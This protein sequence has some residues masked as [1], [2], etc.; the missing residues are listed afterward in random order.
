LKLEYDELLSKPP[1]KFNLH[2]YTKAGRS[3]GGAGAE[4]F[5]CRRALVATGRKVGA[6]T[7]LLFS[8]T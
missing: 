6:Y 1:C 3:A 2:R 8:S 4:L 5:L 7:D